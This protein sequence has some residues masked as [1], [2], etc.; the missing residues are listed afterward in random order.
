MRVRTSPTTV[1]LL[2]V[3]VL[4][5]LVCAA[6][7]TGYFWLRQREHIQRQEIERVIKEKANKLIEKNKAEMERLKRENEAEAREHR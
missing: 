2:I 7:V 5:L 3:G 4:L 6:G 1:A